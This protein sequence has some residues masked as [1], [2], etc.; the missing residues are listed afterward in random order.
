MKIVADENIPYAAEAFGLFGEVTVVSGR[1]ITR[2]LITDADALVVRSITRVD[3]SLLEGTSVRFVGT[4]TNGIDHID[5]DYLAASGISFAH[6]GGSNAMSVAE[7][8]VAALLTLRERGQLH[9]EESRLGII[10]VGEVG[11]RLAVFARG[12]GMSV[13]EYDPPRQS[14]DPEFHSATWD[15]LFTCNVI[16]LHVPLVHDGEHPTR[17]LVDESFLARMMPGSILINTSRG[18]VVRSHDLIDA[19]RAGRP[20]AAVLDVWEGEPS[21]PV[22]LVELLAIATP[23]IAGYAYDAKLRGT[24][25]MSQAL[26]DFTGSEMSWKMEKVLPEV[27]QKIVIPPGLDQLDAM[28]LVA[29]AAID[30]VGDDARLRAALRLDEAGRR[31]EFDRLRREYG[32]RREFWAWGYGGAL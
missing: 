13:V 11:R 4:A 12:F 22:E 23:H 26:A 18:D 9:I 28:S 6:A 31:M 3:R 8:V 20:A 25:M 14:N 32:V 16:S 7:Y 27:H 10:G 24:E 15:D 17:S 30:L 29:G 1:D 21:I 19:L 5:T 2:S